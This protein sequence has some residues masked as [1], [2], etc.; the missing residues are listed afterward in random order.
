MN[1]QLP[2][3]TKKQRAGIIALIVLIVFLQLILFFISTTDDGKELTNYE[4][5]EKLQLQ[6][7]NQKQAL[8]KSYEPQP[9]NPNFITDAKGFKLGMTIEEIDK[10]LA[11]R[12]TGKYVNSAT[13]FQKVTGVSTEWLN[14]NAAYFKFPDFTKNKK[15][16]SYQSQT[17]VS[18]TKIDLN[19]ATVQQLIAIKGIGEYYANAVVNERE[20]LNGFVSKDQI[21]F[22]KGLR[23]EAI[24]A[25]KQNTFVNKPAVK[26]VNVNS[27]SKEDLAEIP[28]I[29]PYI[30]RQ[31]VLLRSK[32]DQ[33]LKIEDLEKIK[34]FP[35]DKLQI[36]RLYLNF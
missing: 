27:A 10:L 22:I 34:N 6:I 24:N 26:K 33:P 21:N 13:E 5:D 9:F 11:F 18:V 23:P 36:I 14:K 31:I 29:T 16:Q 12:A 25:L 4:I 19:K 2:F 17:A 1:V 15:Q 32:T 3:F 8:L 35:L 28:Y 20:Q 7:D 30:A